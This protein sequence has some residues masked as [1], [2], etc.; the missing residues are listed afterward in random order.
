MTSGLIGTN[1]IEQIDHAIG[2]LKN[3]PFANAGL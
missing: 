2:L 1:R 3:L